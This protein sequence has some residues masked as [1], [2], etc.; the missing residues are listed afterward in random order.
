MSCTCR[1]EDDMCPECL[2]KELDEQAILT[3]ELRKD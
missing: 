2:E 1:S 3:E